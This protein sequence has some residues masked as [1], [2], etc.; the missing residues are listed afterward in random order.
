MEG[1]VSPN[2]A[3]TLAVEQHQIDR[4][5]LNRLPAPEPLQL[6]QLRDHRLQ[7]AHVG[8]DAGAWLAF[9]E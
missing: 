5:F 1:R 4:L 7:F 8:A 6:E 3:I 2:D 9:G